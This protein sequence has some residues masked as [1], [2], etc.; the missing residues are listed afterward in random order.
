MRVPSIDQELVHTVWYSLK[1]RTVN[2][3]SGLRAKG[4]FSETSKKP[5]GCA[6]LNFCWNFPVLATLG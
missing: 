6:I 5:F 2:I 1:G 4:N 3:Q